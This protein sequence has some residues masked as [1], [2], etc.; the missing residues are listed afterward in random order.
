M[1][2]SSSKRM[3]RRR[4]IRNRNRMNARSWMRSAKV[5]P[6]SAVWCL[7]RL[8]YD[9]REVGLG[10]AT[11]NRYQKFVVRC[12]CDRIVHAMIDDESWLRPQNSNALIRLN[13]DTIAQF[14][15]F[16]SPLSWSESVCESLITS[17]GWIRVPLATLRLKCF[18]EIGKQHLCRGVTIIRRRWWHPLSW[19]IQHNEQWISLAYV[20]CLESAAGVSR[21]WWV[22]IIADTTELSMG[23]SRNTHTRQR[24]TPTHAHPTNTSIIKRFELLSDSSMCTSLVCLWWT[25]KDIFPPASSVLKTELDSLVCQIALSTLVGFV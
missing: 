4:K 1:W 17:Q 12:C 7:W 23:L 10:L 25:S 24:F 11:T 13:C 6:M 14:I 20:E 2:I 9:W 15:A 16:H 8:K 3:M 21:K 22:H 5:S 18:C 19:E